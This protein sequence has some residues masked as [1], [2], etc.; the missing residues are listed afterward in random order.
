[1]I[2]ALRMAGCVVRGATAAFFAVVLTVTVLCGS[3]AAAR[4]PGSETAATAK[5]HSLAAA[6]DNDPVPIFNYVRN[7]IDY[8]CVW[9]SRRD[10][11]QTMLD[12]T[13]GV[14][15]QCSLLI[16]L[17]RISG[18]TAEYV[19]GTVTLSTAEAAN[20]IGCAEDPITAAENLV[21]GGTMVT[22]VSGETITFHHLWVALDTP[23]GEVL[24]DPALKGYRYKDPLDVAAAAG[25]DQAALLTAL[26]DGATITADYQ[27]NLDLDAFALALNDVATALSTH[28]KNTQPHAALSDLAGGREIVREEVASL[29]VS[30]P[31]IENE[32]ERFTDIPADYRTTVQFVLPGGAS[33][34]AVWTELL[35]RRVTCNYVGGRPELRVDGELKAT[36]ESGSSG[37]L[38]I[39][40]DSRILSSPRTFNKKIYDFRDHAVVLNAGHVS[41]RVIGER[42]RRLQEARAAGLGEE[43]EPVKGEIQNTLGL[44]HFNEVSLYSDLMARMNGL[45]PHRLFGCLVVGGVGFDVL[46]DVRNVYPD[47]HDKDDLGRA[48]KLAYS[49]FTSCSEHGSLEQTQD[50]GEAISTV[51]GL[52]LAMLN[53]QKVFTVTSSNRG[54]VLPQLNYSSSFKDTLSLRLNAGYNITI[55]QSDVTLNEWTGKPWLV[56]KPDGSSYAYQITGPAAILRRRGAVPET[57]FGSLETSTFDALRDYAELLLDLASGDLSALTTLDSPQVAEPVDAFSGALI[58]RQPGLRYYEGRGPQLDIG[59][60]YN[61]TQAA[62]DAGVGHGWRHTYQLEVRD[63]ASNPR[64]ALARGTAYDGVAAALAAHIATQLLR[65]VGTTVPHDRLLASVFV[66]K[67][68]MDWLT[69]TA[70]RVIGPERTQEFLLLPD[71]SYS[72]PAGIFRELQRIGGAYRLTTKYQ[73][74]YQF[75]QEGNLASLTDPAGNALTLTY[76]DGRLDRITDASGRSMDFAYNADGRLQEVR[77]V[78]NRTIE[79]QYDAAGNLLTYTGAEGFDTTYAYDDFHRI[80]NATDP[81]FNTFMTNQYDS[82][83]RVTEQRDGRGKATLFRYAGYITETEDPLGNVTRYEFRENGRLKSETDPGGNSSERSYNGQGL[84]TA[85]TDREGDTTEFTYDERGNVSTARNPRGRV[86][87]YRYNAQNRTI[88]KIDAAQ[89]TWTYEY[90]AGSTLAKIIDPQLKE[91]VFAYNAAG[92]LRTITD[93]D[94][95]VTDYVYDAAGRTEEVRIGPRQTIA[96]TYDDAGRLE[97]RTDGRGNTTTYVYDDRDRIREI[98]APLQRTQSFLYDENGNLTWMQSAAGEETYF[99]YDADNRVTEIIDDAGKRVVYAYDDAGNLRF[100]TDRRDNVT[101]LR[102][103]AL[104]RVE[105]RITPEGLVSTFD[106]TPEGRLQG[107][108]DPRGR[109]T[110]AVYGTMGLKTDAFDP[111][112]HQREYSYDDLNRLESATLPGN[113]VMSFEYDDTGRL[114]AV[115]NPLTRRYEYQRTDAGRLREV[116]YPNTSS[117]SFAYDAGGFLETYRDALDAPAVHQRNADNLPEQVTRRNGTLL[118]YAYDEAARLTSMS[119]GGRAAVA[120]TY[121]KDDR[122][123]SVQNDAGT[124]TYTY[125][126]LGR[127]SSVNDVHGREAAFTRDANG[128]VQTLTLPGSRTVTYAYDK[129]NRLVTVTDWENRAVS[130]EYDGLSNVTRIQYPNGVVTEQN[131]DDAGRLTGL[132]HTGPGGVIAAYTLTRDERGF[133]TSVDADLA[134]T[135]PPQPGVVSASYNAANRIEMRNGGAYGYDASGYL[136]SGGGRTLTHDDFGRLESVQTGSGIVSVDVNG[137]G[138]LV[139]ADDGG[140]AVEYLAVGGNVLA[141]FSGDDSAEAFYIYGLGL[142]ARIDPVGDVSY[143]HGDFRGN[144]VALTGGAGQVTDTYAYA[145][146]GELLAHNGTSDQPFRFG[147]QLGLFTLDAA[148]LVWMRSRWYDPATGRFI[149]EDPAGF[150]GGFNLYEYAGNDPV[151]FIDPAGTAAEPVAHAIGDLS[152]FLQTS[153]NTLLN[154][155]EEIADQLYQQHTAS[156][157][158]FLER[159]IDIFESQI[160]KIQLQQNTVNE[161]IAELETIIPTVQSEALKERLRYELVGEKKD[162]EYLALE[163][164]HGEKA[165]DEFRSTLD[166]IRNGTASP[167]LLARVM[168]ELQDAKDGY[169]EHSGMTLGPPGHSLTV[170]RYIHSKF[171]KVTSESTY[172]MGTH[173]QGMG[174]VPHLPG[175]VSD[176]PNYIPGQYTGSTK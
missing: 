36:G 1:M 144:I 69:R 100:V 43:A 94:N 5:I 8:E 91:T 142:V 52:Y 89:T 134:A 38:Q 173:V 169:D 83:G 50:V 44:S 133:V 120:Y 85:I 114:S 146:Y 166:Q 156:A 27:Q 77:D 18:H 62:V 39:T 61:S 162:Q 139:G 176:T 73:A 123:K 140:T 143:C 107:F 111:L 113:R 109:T 32:I 132:I 160:D 138:S 20:W 118:Q 28:L 96:F 93:P 59:L 56:W 24:L 147:G 116:S 33:Y 35:Y 4:G 49:S 101:E 10:A 129:D 87:S 130:Y 106:Y 115:V 65:G 55:P 108:M 23:S 164:S 128:N 21:N 92:Q 12:R 66:H 57:T 125:D 48:H 26:S 154:Q 63:N 97:T 67:W 155:A 68:L 71:G 104:N 84:L 41:A 81:L 175:G 168:E 13:G 135:G 98:Q 42:S 31:Y 2:S 16:A 75:N 11:T 78:L 165:V 112:V 163:I 17:L 25:Y 167:E 110:T 45:V 7:T 124:V 15:D 172:S 72:H 86:T 29:P 121:T 37:T 99:N 119:A 76:A 127:V 117:V 70:V 122:F 80:L 148:S 158:T 161:Q 171:H 34:Q 9:S 54:T 174:F 152:D 105:E 53:G 159:E 74:V 150:R 79:F 102:Y 137:L 145:P 103:N 141:T 131:Y 60:T 82:F 51:K 149:S 46:L 95:V 47:N 151:N 90:G 58:H 6:L 22:M 3:G 30:L 19:R 157:Q 153:S 170:K 88:E 136:L 64:R 126:N 40:I 14:F